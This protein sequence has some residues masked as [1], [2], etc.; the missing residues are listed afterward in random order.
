M[1]EQRSRTGAALDISDAAH[2]KIGEASMLVVPRGVDNFG[3][4]GEGVR[5]DRRQGRNAGR[6]FQKMSAS[7]TERLD[8]HFAECAHVPT[9]KSTIERKNQWELE[10][11]ESARR[12]ARG[13]RPSKRRMWRAI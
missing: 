2:G 12:N 1:N 10:F 11:P 5:L 6:K 9:Q 4:P 3:P 8:A 13:G 7:H